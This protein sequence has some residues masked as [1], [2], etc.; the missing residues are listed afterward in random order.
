MR[1]AI[2]WIELTG[3]LNSCLRELALRPGVELFVAHTPPDSNSPFYE[4]QFAWLSQQFVW[5]TY[6]DLDSL[7]GLLDAFRP[8]VVVTCGWSVPTYRRVARRWRSRAICIM[9]MDNCWSGKL[10]QWVGLIVAPLFL[11]SWVDAIW[12]PGER[13]SRFAA[14]LH[15]K[16]RAIL[17]GLY[18]CDYSAFSAVYEARLRH[19]RPLVRAFM[20]VGRMVEEK[21]VPTLVAAYRLYRS[22]ARV[23]WPL[24]CCGRGPLA[25]MLEGEPGVVV[26]GFVQPDSLPE[27]LAEGACLV[28]PSSF[29]PW[30]VVVHEATAAGLLIL[31]S[32]AVGSTPHLVQDCYNGFIFDVGDAEGLS[33]LMER[34]GLLSEEKLNRMAAASSSLACQFT[35]TRW[36]DTLLDFAERARQLAHFE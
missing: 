25:A 33:R 4:E 3:Y 27:K 19:E 12:L 14:K 28:L 10:R 15:F 8:D 1:L 23:P 30:A 5:R 32:D 35:P 7:D 13:Q 9:T 24:I 16:Q 26:Q 29:E 6:S 21:G 36:A 34:V 2:L 11:R 22:R 31:A 17:R 18:S 20:F